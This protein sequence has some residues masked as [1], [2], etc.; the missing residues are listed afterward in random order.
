MKQLLLSLFLVFGLVLTASA[1]REFYYSESNTVYRGS[2]GVSIA[3]YPNPTSDAITI[4]DNDLVKSITLYNL[5]GKRVR[6]F[7]YYKGEVYNIE[8]LPQ[9]LYLLQLIDNNGRVLASTRLNKL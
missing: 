1:Q 7:R 3:V 2:N 4:S 6:Q 9:G 8:E 5:V